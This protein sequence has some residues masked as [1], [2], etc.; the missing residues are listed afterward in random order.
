[1][2]E[3]AE[4]KLVSFLKEHQ[5]FPPPAS[6]EL[7]R[8]LFEA[9]AQESKSSVVPLTKQKNIFPLGNWK[10]ALVACGLLLGIGISLNNYNLSQR[11]GLEAEILDQTDIS[12]LYVIDPDTGLYDVSL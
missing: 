2:N 4:D 6:M 8:S 11:E 9:I 5:P 3:P 1:M 12:S 10:L 7:E